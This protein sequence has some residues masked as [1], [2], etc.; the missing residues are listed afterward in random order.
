MTSLWPIF[1][2]SINYHSIGRYTNP[3]SRE[4]LTREAAHYL[5][6]RYVR[7]YSNPLPLSPSISLFS[8]DGSVDRGIDR[9]D[10]DGNSIEGG[11][12]ILN[13]FKKLLSSGKEYTY[14]G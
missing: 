12:K 5:Y 11:K 9:S 6:Y 7:Y 13:S 1:H 2:R 10:I 4:L 8:K 14:Q 3:K